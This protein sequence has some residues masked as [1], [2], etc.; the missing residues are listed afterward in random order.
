[1]TPV[2]LPFPFRTALHRFNNL[3]LHHSLL[4]TRQRT[5]RSGSRVSAHRL[6]LSFHFVLFSFLFFCFLFFVAFLLRK[7]GVSATETCIIITETGVSGKK[8][9]RFSGSVFSFI[10]IC[11][12]SRQTA[13]S[14][15][16]CS[17][18]RTT[19][20]FRRECC[21]GRRSAHPSAT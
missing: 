6:L 14:R 13:D 18:A 3:S 10:Q 11:C 4:M 16:S 5:T 7:P 20:S 1:M 19:A 8:H 9:C 12:D 21:R 15:A 17:Q 2:I